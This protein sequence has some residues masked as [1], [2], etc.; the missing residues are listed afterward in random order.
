MPNPSI[1]TLLAAGLLAVVSVGCDKP[2]AND[3]PAPPPA[4]PPAP[5]NPPANAEAAPAANAAPPVHQSALEKLTTTMVDKQK[6]MAENPSMVEIKKNSVEGSDPITAAASGYF[7]AV[8]QFTLSAIQHDIELTKLQNDDKYPTFE[9]YSDI[10]RRNGVKLRGLHKWQV[11]A[12]DQKD[13][14]IS[15]LED[16]Q[17]KK[18]IY[19]KAGLEYK[20]EM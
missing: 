10:L 6:A 19:E 4:V 9:E 7:A 17:K 16:R 1:R 15:I 20:D 3:T 8:S 13:G 11:Y 12:Y 5:A 14:K 18:E 2:A